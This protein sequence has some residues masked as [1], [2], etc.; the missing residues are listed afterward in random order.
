MKKN[1]FC[2]WLVLLAILFSV[3]TQAQIT[4][5]G[6]KEPEAFSVLELLNKGGL[7]L[8]QMSTAERDAFAVQG[9]DKGS[10]LT[11]YNKTTGCVEYWNKT[12]W[13]SLCDDTS[14]NALIA[15]D[16][17]LTATIGNV[18]LGG[19][20]I[21]PSVVATSAVNTLGVTG[22][23]NSTDSADTP[24][25][26]T[27]DG[28]LKKGAFPQVNVVPSD[29]GTVIAIDGKLVVAQEITA[30]MTANF[31]FPA[32]GS[33][34]VPIGNITNVL[35]D[36]QGAFTSNATSNSFNVNA[37]GVYLVNISFPMINSGGVPAM[38]VWCNTDNK[39]AA[40]INLLMTNN[41]TNYI[42][43][44]AIT[45]DSSKIYSFRVSNT[46]SSTIEA[47]NSGSTG[48]GPVA[49]FSIKRLK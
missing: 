8:P 28:T 34:T 36:N 23:V 22:L 48:I 10:G 41:R 47:F 43:M 42:L 15:A 27:A 38:G 35:I 37:N 24:L 4:V 49:F 12:R 19:T 33:T 26:I 44:T 21:K 5:G 31:S 39:W 45:M 25:V 29:I 13:V 16:N 7:R 40:R 3:N 1:L 46:E 18:Q 2:I 11:I 32:S 6:K 9:N 14:V 30:L 20:L 17:G